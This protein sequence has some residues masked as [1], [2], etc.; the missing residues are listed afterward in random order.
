MY[1]FTKHLCLTVVCIL[2]FSSCTTDNDIPE[3]NTAIKTADLVDYVTYSQ[4]E[5]EI[6]DAVNDHR[7]SLG[8]SVLKRVDGITFQAHDH[9]KYMIQNNKV[10]HD[11]FSER[12]IALVNEIGAK[13]VG[14][15][16]AYGYQTSGAVIKA[17]LNSEG[18]RENLEGDHTHFGIAVSQD[19]QGRNYFTNIFVRR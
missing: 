14:E 11:N 4:I 17:W 19:A 15:N 18:H 16:L 12:Y 10:S 8:L 5:E 1:T 9:N 7:I 6:M 2:M 3:E 13:A